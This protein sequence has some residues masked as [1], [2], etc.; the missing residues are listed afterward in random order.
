MKI[1]TGD[2]RMKKQL[3]NKNIEPCCEICTFGIILADDS[4]VLCKKCGIRNFDSSCRK[5][6]Y[7]P[8]KRVPRKS[9]A[10]AGFSKEDF[11]L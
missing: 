2:D 1:K 9:P 3:L 5:F 11:E 8:L 4:G 7:D 6:K 10:M